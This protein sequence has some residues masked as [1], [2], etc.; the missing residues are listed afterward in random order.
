M[1]LSLWAKCS[2]L[3]MAWI[4]HCLTSCRFLVQKVL[5]GYQVK[6]ESWTKSQEA[7]V[8]SCMNN[9]K[10][11]SLILRVSISLLTEPK[12]QFFSC[13]LHN[14]VEK[15]SNVIINMTTHTHVRTLSLTYT[16]MCTCTHKSTLESFSFYYPSQWRATLWGPQ[17]HG[18]SWAGGHPTKEG[19]GE[20]TAHHSWS[21]QNKKKQT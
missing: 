2:F 18:V 15:L 21:K 5:R 4:N 20:G 8:L 17:G 13:L 7:E 3:D 1:C 16:H 12:F 19:V 6:S 11:V 10:R 14:I 9:L